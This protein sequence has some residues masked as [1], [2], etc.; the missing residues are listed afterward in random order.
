MA[1]Q[2]GNSNDNVLVHVQNPAKPPLIEVHVNEKSLHLQYGGLEDALNT[3][4]RR[5]IRVP[6]NEMDIDS[7]PR[8]SRLYLWHGCLHA[9]RFTTTVDY[10]SRFPSDIAEKRGVFFPMYQREAIWI[11]FAARLLFAIKIYVSDFNAV[12][13]RP[14]DEDEETKQELRDKLS[15]RESVQDY[16]VVPAQPW[17]DG[18]VCKDGKSRQF[19]AHRRD[20]GFSIEAHITGKD[21]LS[22]IQIEVVPIKCKFL[23]EIE[24]RGNLACL[25]TTQILF[26]YVPWQHCSPIQRDAKMEDYC[27]G[28][29]FVL[30]FSHDKQHLAAPPRW[31]F[32]SGMPSYEISE[33]PPSYDNLMISIEQMNMAAGRL[34]KQTIIPDPHRS[35]AWDVAALILSHVHVLDPASFTAVTGLP[36]PI[37]AK[38]YPEHDT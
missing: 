34:I 37:S 13:G 6:D 36:T 21:S 38:K 10:P 35:D 24:V 11:D 12:S 30:G 19:V 5:N 31:G 27:F 29:N 18:I 32:A 28:L 3:T 1:T 4:F 15:R 26:P 25:P 33:M 2:H 17:L 22:V 23:E 8:L 7:L 9:S 20:S 14:I 16:M